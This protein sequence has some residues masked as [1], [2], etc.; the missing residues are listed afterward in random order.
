MTLPLRNLAPM[1]AV[2][3]VERAR[4]FYVN[5]LGFTLLNQMEFHGKL[6]WCL[7]GAGGPSGGHDS[8]WKVELM[9]TRDETPAGQEAAVAAARRGV[10]LYFYPTEDITALHAKYASAGVKVSPLRV[11]FYEMK[12]FTIEDPHGYQVWFG[13]NTTDPPTPCAHE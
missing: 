4:D 10:I 12:E 5:I 9:F 8:P 6:G 7:V 13:Q 2:E 11:T 3:S 1:L